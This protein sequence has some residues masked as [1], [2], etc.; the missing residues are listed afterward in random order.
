[1]PAAHQRS[2]MLP[3][4]QFFTFREWV[5]AMEIIDSMVSA[6]QFLGQ[7]LELLLLGQLS[8]QLPRLKHRLGAHALENVARLTPLT[9]PRRLTSLSC[10]RLT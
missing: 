9:C 5:R 8:Y 6:V 7:R 3:L 1:M 4:C 10:G 2:A